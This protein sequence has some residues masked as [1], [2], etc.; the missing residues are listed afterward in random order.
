MRMSFEDGVPETHRADA[1]RTDGT[2][3]DARIREMLT[4]KL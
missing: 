1:L 3:G 2:S 4:E